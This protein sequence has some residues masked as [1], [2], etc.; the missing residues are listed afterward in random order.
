MERE[1]NL[2]IRSRRA[3]SDRCLPTWLGRSLQ[4]YDNPRFLE[5]RNV[6]STLQCKRNDGSFIKLEGLHYQP[7]RKNNTGIVRQYHYSGIHKSHGWLS[8]RADRNCKVDMGRGYNEQYNNCCTA[9]EWQAECSGR[10][11]IKNGRQTRVDV[12]E[13]NVSVLGLNV[14]SS[15]N[16]PICIRNFYSASNVQQQISRPKWYEVRCS[17]SE[18]L[19]NGKQLCKSS[20]KTSRPSYICHKKSASSCHSN[21]T[22][23]ACS[24]MVQISETVSNM[25]SSQSEHK[26]NY[27]TEPRHTRT[28]TKQKMETFRLETLWEQRALQQNWSVQAASRLKFGL[29]KSTT[30]NYNMY[31]EKIVKLC[32]EFGEEFPPTT[33][34]TLAECLLIISSDSNRPLSMLNC[35]L[36]ALSHVY[37]AYHKTDLTNDIL[38][39]KLVSGIVKSSTN[40][41]RMM[42]KVMPIDSFSNFFINWDSNFINIKN[43][44]LKCI[45][46]LAIVTMLRPSDIAPK[47]LYVD[48]KGF[49][50]NYSFTEDQVIFKE[51]GSMSIIIHGNKNDTKRHGFVVD[52]TPSSVT[53]LCPVYTMKCYLNRTKIY[54]KDNGPVFIALKSPYGALSSQAITNILNESIALVGLPRN[55]YSAKCFRPSGATKAISEGFDPNMVQ[56]VGRWKTPTVFF[57]HYVHSQVPKNFTDSLLSVER[58]NS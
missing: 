58:T 44:R 53:N 31:I 33:S 17:G 22:M 4:R 29:A 48:E 23:V 28:T 54:R 20:Y 30:N 38:I 56:K 14:G 6:S 46:L 40:S 50:H 13:T 34:S 16:R 3:A 10:Y 15:H 27:P 45:C 19:G 41:P 43:L 57:E 9:L 42:S 39:K 55:I 52:V 1:S 7:K 11:A 12:V 49:V 37:I 32:N 18:G 35:V 36:S 25:P 26:S 5:S 2:A 24:D 47:A 51:N 8:D 21:S